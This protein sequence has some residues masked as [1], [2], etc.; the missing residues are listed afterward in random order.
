M[1]YTSENKISHEKDEMKNIP[2]KINKFLKNLNKCQPSVN[3][4]KTV[5]EPKNFSPIFMFLF[6]YLL[7]QDNSGFQKNIFFRFDSFEVW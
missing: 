2:V 6:L 5:V 1:V 4:T 7:D 3:P